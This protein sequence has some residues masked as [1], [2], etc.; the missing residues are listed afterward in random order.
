VVWGQTLQ[1]VLTG[2]ACRPD[3]EQGTRTERPLRVIHRSIGDSDIYFVANPSSNAVIADCSFRVSGKEP[4]IWRPETGE[5]RLAGIWNTNIPGTVT[6]QVRLGPIG[7][8]FVVFRAPIVDTDPVV[9]F[10]VDRNVDDSAELYRT[11]E[12]KLML[13][14]NRKGSY[15]IEH[16]SGRLVT[17]T[18]S[19][20][21]PP[22]RVE[23]AWNARF[24][25]TPASSKTEVFERLI[26]WTEHRDPA[27]K[28][29]SGTAS[30]QK[31]LNIPAPYFAKGNRLKLDLGQVRV[32]A[33]VKVN[34]QGVGILWKPPFVVDITNAA[35]EG[36]NTLDIAV[37]NL[38]PN[39]LIGDEQLPDDCEWQNPVGETGTGLKNWPTW[40]TEGKSSPSRRSSF[41]TWKFYTKDSPLLES[42]LLGPVELRTEALLEVE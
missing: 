23:G 6:T 29:F 25:T 9:R 24:P 2:L 30:Y 5:V 13:S 39:R 31:I 37:V 34:G 41:T 32:I 15:A 16:R 8:C 17:A 33:E 35:K 21:A 14:A 19:E 40:L 1:N 36:A 20:L 28:Y 3:F 7:S 22:I 27:I 10:T 38:W 26:S 11:P 18:V 4:E 42:G 12:G